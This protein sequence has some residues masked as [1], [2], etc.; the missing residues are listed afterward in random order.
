MKMKLM[1]TLNNGGVVEKGALKIQTKMGEIG[2]K[3][4]AGLDSERNWGRQTGEI[5]RENQCEDELGGESRTHT[6][7]RGRRL[8]RLENSVHSMTVAG[9][10]Q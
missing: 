5:L 6:H 8:L 9:V 4:D 3:P 1:S 10:H 2:G 7:R